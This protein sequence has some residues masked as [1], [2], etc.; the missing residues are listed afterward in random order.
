MNDVSD[1]L[2]VFFQFA[3]R[4]YNITT[5]WYFHFLNYVYAVITI[6]LQN[7]TFTFRIRSFCKL[8]FLTA[9]LKTTKNFTL[10]DKCATEA[11][12]RR[13]SVKKVFLE[14]LQSTQENTCAR[15]YFFNKVAGLSHEYQNFLMMMMM[16]MMMIII[17]III[18]TLFSVDFHITITI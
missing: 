4:N 3:W 5:K 18:I 12:A 17:I 1:H 7:D 16:M 2:S 8:L 11:V 9:I 14:I 13:C 6:K 15:V 10:C